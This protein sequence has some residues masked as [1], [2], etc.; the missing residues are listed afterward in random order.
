MKTVAIIPAR[1]ASS[2]LEGKPLLDIAGKPMIRRVYEAASGAKLIDRVIVATDDRRILDTVAG[3]GGEAKLT[4]ANHASG[5]DRV[6]EVAGQLPCDTV[7]N[8]QGDEP[9][10][11]PQ[12]IDELV[13]S[14]LEDQDVYMASAQSPIRI[15]THL[16]NPNIVKVVSDHD[17]Y[18]LYFSRSPFLTTSAVIM[19]IGVFWASSTLAFIFT[20]K[21]F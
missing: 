6:A 14:L 15:R 4:S 20:G 5:T 8:L 2:R 13:R 21:I 10:M 17:D 3:F 7:V 16:T 12:I 11:E 1:Y 19:L 9:L 18:A